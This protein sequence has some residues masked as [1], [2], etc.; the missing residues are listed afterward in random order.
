MPT[1]ERQ[2]TKIKIKKTKQKLIRY[3]KECM[4]PQREN[5]VKMF[6]LLKSI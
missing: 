3:N 4:Q 1:K 6:T 2:P 5:K